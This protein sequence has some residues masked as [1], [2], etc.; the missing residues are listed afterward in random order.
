MQA[1]LPVTGADLSITARSRM[2][3]DLVVLH[4]AVEKSGQK[5]RHD[6]LVAAAEAT[7]PHTGS[8]AGFQ[9]VAAV[10]S[11]FSTDLWWG[12]GWS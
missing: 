11:V 8:A 2:D 3:V 7:R 12:K 1:H 6:V 4:R 5:A 10:M 9:S